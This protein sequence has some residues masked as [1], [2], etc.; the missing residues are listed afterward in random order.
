MV[1]DTKTQKKYKITTNAS[2][3]GELKQCLSD[4]GIDYSGMS[5]TEGITK[6][7]LMDDSAQLPTNIPYKG[8]TTNNLVLLLTNTRKNIASGAMDRKDAYSYIKDNLLQDKVEEA[9]GRN[10]TQVSTAALETF[11]SNHCGSDA[12]SPSHEDSQKKESGSSEDTKE[13]KASVVEMKSPGIKDIIIDLCKRLAD[14]GLLSADD[15]DDIADEVGFY[16]ADSDF[17]VDNMVKEL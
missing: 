8:T 5:F 4:N 6:T 15:L 13:I 14:K 11:I 7:T 10:F 16:E 12:A 17:D 1:A 2:T 3:L 9:F